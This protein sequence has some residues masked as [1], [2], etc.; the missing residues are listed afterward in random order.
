MVILAFFY[1][2]CK[3]P[4]PGRDFSRGG[5][6]KGKRAPG[7]GVAACRKL[8]YGETDKEQEASREAAQQPA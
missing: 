7:K 3:K 6:C 1:E 8:Q 2:F 5:G 4:V